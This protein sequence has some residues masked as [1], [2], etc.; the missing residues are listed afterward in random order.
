MGSWTNILGKKQSSLWRR[1]FLGKDVIWC[2]ASSQSERMRQV[3]KSD[4]VRFQFSQNLKRWCSMFKLKKSKSWNGVFL[5]FGKVEKLESEKS[6]SSRNEGQLEDWLFW[7]LFKI[8]TSKTSWTIREAM[9][10]FGWNMARFVGKCPM[11]LA[12]LYSMGVDIWNLVV[13][14]RLPEASAWKST[15]ETP[16][17]SPHGATILYS[18]K[19]V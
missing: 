18:S 7:A 17:C 15:W 19:E 16:L 4:T 11:D 13:F 10:L 3:E 12:H 14:L 1:T 6:E 2:D 9:Y 8:L 5:N